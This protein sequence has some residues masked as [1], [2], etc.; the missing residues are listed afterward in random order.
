MSILHDGQAHGNTGEVLNLTSKSGKKQPWRRHKYFSQKVAESYLRL[1]NNT[2]FDTARFQWYYDEDEELYDIVK[3]RTP[4]DRKAES[5][6]SCASWLKVGTC[7]NG[8]RQ[9]TG[10]SFCRARLCPMCAWRRSLL[11]AHQIKRVGHEV[12]QQFKV[13]WLFL[14]LTVRNVPFEELRDSIDLLMKAFRKLSMYK[15]FKN[16]VLGWYRSLEVTRNLDKHSEWF[17]TFHPHLHVLLCVKP[18][19]FNSSKKYI[20]QAEWTA[21]W[22]KAL[23]VTYDPIVHVQVVKPKRNKKIEADLLAEYGLD[24][25]DVE[26]SQEL[27]GAAIAETAKYSVKPSELV[28]FSD[29]CYCSGDECK[30]GHVQKDFTEHKIDEEETDFSVFAFDYVLSRRRLKAYGG[31]LKEVWNRLREEEN[32]KDPEADDADLVMVTEDEKCKCSTCQSALLETLYR[33]MPG[34][35]NYVG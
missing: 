28:V 35:N 4:Y 3:L 17:G 12:A 18:S 26:G 30:C 15:R 6:L 27:T 23:R 10:A 34:I 13:R 7:A 32:M 1:A 5:I 19:Y 22:R 20:D 24:V 25:G 14:T 31:L 16:A 9:L 2:H 21:M 29:A 8:H 11:I 33:W